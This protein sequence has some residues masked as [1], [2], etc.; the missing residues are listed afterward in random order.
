MK[1]YFFFIAIIIAVAS[2][3]MLTSCEPDTPKNESVDII[4]TL[5][6]SKDLMDNVNPEVT[7][8]DERGVMAK[9]DIIESDWQMVTMDGIEIYKW[10]KNIHYNFYGVS[11][12]ISVTYKPKGEIYAN[13]DSKLTYIFCH[14]LNC[15]AK[16]DGRTET[17]DGGMSLSKIQVTGANIRDYIITL[18]ENSDAASCTIDSNGNIS[19]IGNGFSTSEV[20]Y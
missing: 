8:T 13:I 16:A 3:S 6:I 7:Y 17:G 5:I 9:I 14:G 15:Y 4:Y 20:N 19:V 1:R 11:N 10:V 2:T 18:K 12:N